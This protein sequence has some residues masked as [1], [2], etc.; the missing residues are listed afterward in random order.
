M[1]INKIRGHGVPEV[2]LPELPFFDQGLDLVDTLKKSLR[3][4]GAQVTELKKSDLIS[5]LNQKFSSAQNVFSVIPERPGNIQVTET[6]DPH[7]LDDVEIAVLNAEFGVA[8]TG[9]LWID[10]SG[11]VMP[12]IPFI[13]QHLIVILDQKN[14]VE[15]MHQAYAKM[16][17]RK[18]SFGLFI[19]GPSK[20]AD[21]EQSLVIGAHG[22]LSLTVF[23]ITD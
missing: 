21:I 16:D 5:K 19:A 13:V 18:Q 17:I 11:M 20:T 4:N 7:L 22:S 3:L 6:S 12:V 10:S 9:A 1:I 2:P 23:L 14:L 8:E 15:N